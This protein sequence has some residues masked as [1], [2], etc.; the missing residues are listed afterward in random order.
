MR[1]PTRSASWPRAPDAR[2]HGLAAIVRAVPDE[3]QRTPLYAR[4]VESGGRLVPFA[5]WEM[6]VQYA[7]VID[8]VRAV[9]TACRAVR[10]LAHGAGAGRRE[11][12]A[13]VPA[14]RALERPRPPDAR[15]RAVHAADERARRDRRRPDRVPA[16]RGLPARRQRRQPRG[17]RRAPRRPLPGRLPPSSTTRTPTACSPCRA[18]R[19]SRCSRRCARAS[20]RSRPRRSRSRRRAS[21][22]SSAPSRAP[23]TRAR[24]APS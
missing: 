23:A 10:R 24:R 2:A 4:H 8:E 6:P 20:I 13:R 9:R 14:G 5:G 7:G 12:G 16:R 15:A 11:R 22:A 3:L 17:R 19:R 18:R 1:W 21:R